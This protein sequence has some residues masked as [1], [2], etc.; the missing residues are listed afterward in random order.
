[1]ISQQLTRGCFSSV[2]FSVAFSLAGTGK[3]TVAVLYAEI[4]T[5]LGLLSKGEVVKKTGTDFIGAVQGGSASQTNAILKASEGCVLLIDEVCLLLQLHDDGRDARDDRA[6]KQAL[7]LFLLSLFLLTQAYGLFPGKSGN[8]DPYKEAVITAL[9]E[10]VQNVPGNDRCVLMLGYA[11]EMGEMMRDSNPGLA[12]RFAVANAFTFAD[13]SD[14]ELMKMLSASLEQQHITAP[15][16]AKMAAVECLAYQRRLPNFGNGGAVNNLISAAKM[17]AQQR[18]SS[19]SAAGAAPSFRSGLVLESADFVP[20]VK[21]I[22]SQISDVFS[23]VIGCAS[24]L[25]ELRK[26]YS[27]IQ[28]KKKRGEDFMNTVTLNWQF[29]GPPGTG[30]SWHAQRSLFAVARLHSDAAL[31]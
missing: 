18:M 25:A 31:C 6:S 1:M 21:D 20:P 30:Q 2:S 12:R 24:V 14:D 17:R 23:G 19:A 28:A 8:I 26:T 9:V 5:A 16:A 27:V 22:E 15:F 13:Y 4:L 10:K 11:K 3:T 7:T 29:A